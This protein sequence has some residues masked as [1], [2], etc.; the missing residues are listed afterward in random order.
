[1]FAKSK[2]T[3]FKA[4]KV[5]GGSGIADYHSFRI[6]S[7]GRDPE[8]PQGIQIKQVNRIGDNWY[9]EDCKVDFKAKDVH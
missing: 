1:M 4:S 6:L 5:V 8:N 2:N 3:D 9:Y 7:A